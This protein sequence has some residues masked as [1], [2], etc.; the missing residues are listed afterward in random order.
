MHR[1]NPQ[2]K[3]PLSGIP[4]EISLEEAGDW[5]GAPLMPGWRGIDVVAVRGWQIG[6]GSWSLSD[7]LRLGRHLSR[8]SPLDA[9]IIENVRIWKHALLRSPTHYLLF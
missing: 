1:C 9:S 8:A 7:L 4:I 2:A 6:Y 5:I 3:E